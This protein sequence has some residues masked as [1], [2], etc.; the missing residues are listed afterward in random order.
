MRNLLKAKSF[1]ILIAVVLILF[2][3]MMYSASTSGQQ[4]FLTAV[5]S[6][7]TTPIQKLSALIS[8]GIGSIGDDMTDIDTVRAENELLLTKVR[9][10]SAQLVDYEELKQENERLRGILGIKEENPGF[11]FVPATVI[12]RDVSDPYATFIIDK[13]SMH[14]V[15]YLDPVI[16]A[17]GLVGYVSEVGP[18]SSKVTTILSPATDIGAIDRRTLDGGVLGGDLELAG[19]DMCKLSYLARDCDVATGDIIVTSGLGCIYP[20]N[21]VIGEVTEIRAESQDIS[22]YAIIQPAADVTGCIDVFVISSFEGQ[23]AVVNGQLAD[24]VTTT[25]E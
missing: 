19:N 15:A 8:G 2:G 4:N 10:L 5:T 9:E 21:L 12:S 18:I 22:L 25:A 17:D 16:T 11:Q 23:G 7:I 6:F 20:K 3:V 24:T 13:G 1:K 14:D